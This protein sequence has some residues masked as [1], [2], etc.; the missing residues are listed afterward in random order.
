MLVLIRRA[1]RGK[2][3]VGKVIEATGYH[4]VGC[5]ASMRSRSI[6]YEKI[7]ERVRN[8]GQC[9]VLVDAMKPGLL[10]DF[11]L[12]CTGRNAVVWFRR[13]SGSQMRKAHHA[14]GTFR[15]RRAANSSIARHVF[16]TRFK[17]CFLRLIQAQA[18]VTV[19]FVARA[20]VTLGNSPS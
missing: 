20:R 6:S 18:S 17:A 16:T 3:W 13:T 12:Q 4:C 14:N 19:L 1:G 11:D 15:R 5:S 9:E 2:R 7:L 8:F 10:L